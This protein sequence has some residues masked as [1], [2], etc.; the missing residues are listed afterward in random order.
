MA[1]LCF[2]NDRMNH[3]DHQHH[4]QHDARKLGIAVALTLVFAAVEL[5]AGWWGNSLALM[6]DAG[7]MLVDSTSLTL[8]A[9]AAWYAGRKST[10]RRSWG[11]GRAEVLAAL[12]NTSIMLVL[13][14]FIVYHAW[15]RLHTPLPIA[16]GTVLVV[17]ALGLII[18]LGVLW[19]ISGGRQ[20]LNTRAARLHVLG[21]LLGSFAAITAGVVVMTTGWTPIDPILSLLISAL[22]LHSALRLLRASVDVVMEAVPATIDPEQV[23]ACMCQ[24]DGVVAVHDLHI[25]QISSARIAL[26]AHVV[27]AD[28]LQWP[29]QVLQ[30][31]SLLAEQFSIDHPTLQPEHT[32]ADRYCAVDAVVCE[33]QESST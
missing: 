19:V 18:N 5:V 21:D 9:L 14:G 8:A 29:K 6:A 10:Q 23:R 15:Q 28:L 13:I 1:C 7:H 27:V 31:Q 30:L 3:H 4:D 22:L 26:S 24:V 32:D 33:M 11:N 16:G 17:A 20:S 12:I 25:W 2:Y